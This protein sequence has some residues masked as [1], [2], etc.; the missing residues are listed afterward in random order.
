M[1]VG[2]RAW[3]R[4]WVGVGERVG[5]CGRERAWYSEKVGV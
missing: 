3:E 5:W 4:E 1:G 2:E